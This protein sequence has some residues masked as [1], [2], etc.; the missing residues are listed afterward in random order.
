MG[1]RGKGE[2]ARASVK[3]VSAAVARYVAAILGV[4]VVLAAALFIGRSEHV[5]SV[6]LLAVVTASAYFGGLG[7]G[8]V[9]TGLS[10]FA[11]DF[12][13]FP[14]KLSWTLGAATWIW[15]AGYI[16]TAVLINWF[17]AAQ[18]RAVATLALAGQRKSAFMAMLAHELRNFLSPVSTALMAI[19]LNVPDDP[20]VSEACDIADRQI[21]NMG[22]LIEE[23]LDVARVTQGKA[24]LDLQPVDLVAVL[25]AALVGARPLIETRGH[26][27]E[28]TIPKGP[29]I[30]R[31][32]PTRLEQVFVNLLTNAA[33]YTEPG[34]KI[35]VTAERRD[36]QLAVRVRDNG[37]GL[38]PEVLP[39]VFELFMQGDVSSGGGLGIGLSL[40]RVLVEMHGGSVAAE[41]PGPGR[42]SQFVVFLPAVTGLSDAPE[43]Y[44]RGPLSPEAGSGASA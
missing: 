2:G 37:R 20:T 34:G 25:E 44:R 1:G 10:A 3:R 13:F 19:R 43:G 28:M 33:K 8:L 38:S 21:K 35:W 12:F 29:L 9:A 11:L 6:F 22:A 42:G 16:G 32:D 24:N 41:S 31:G 30:L 40:V 5:A 27:V 17:Q 4:G 14:P 23:L 39:H 15:L 36:R 18:R 26:E 7:P